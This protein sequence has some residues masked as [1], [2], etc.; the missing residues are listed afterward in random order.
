MKKT[1]LIK[2]ILLILLSVV[3]IGSTSVFAAD[4]VEDLLLD[5]GNE[6]SSGTTDTPTSTPETITTPTTPT[7]TTNNE[8][9]TGNSSVYNNDTTPAPTTTT[10]EKKEDKSL[11]NT[12]IEDTIP[13]V[14]LIAVFGISAVFAYKKIRDY[15]NV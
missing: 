15:K 14:T 3:L 12:G 10:T 5:F 7:T 13:M 2:G 1:S 8:V 11:S 4:S 6:S 9:P